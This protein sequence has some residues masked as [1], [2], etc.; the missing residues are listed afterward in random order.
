VLSVPGVTHVIV[1][2]GVND[3][4]LGYAKLEGPLAALMPPPAVKPT[5][6]AMIAG[7]RQLIGA[8]ARKGLKTRATIAPYE[9]AV[10]YST[11][12]NG[13]RQSINDWMRTS[14]GVRRGARLRRGVS[15][16]GEPTQMKDAFQAGDHL[17]GS[18][19]GYKAV[20]RVGESRS[21]PVEPRP[22]ALLAG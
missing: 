18:D 17:H 19:A 1:F 2:E 22:A 8:R 13:V 10:Y 14:Q 15:R 7:Y 3:L 5:R 6:D 12:G 4:G 11:E 21:V 20:G 16:S 9:G